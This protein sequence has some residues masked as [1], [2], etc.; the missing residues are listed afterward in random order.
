MAKYWI[1]ETPFWSA[2]LRL[3]P[4][5]EPITLE[6]IGVGKPSPNW[7]EVEQDPED[8][9]PRRGRPKSIG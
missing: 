7:E 6:D 5:G 8:E 1:S 9:A 3:I 4:A 2:S